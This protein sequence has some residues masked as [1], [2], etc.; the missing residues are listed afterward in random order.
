MGK[1]KVHSGEE[2]IRKL[3]QAEVLLHGGNQQRVTKLVGLLGLSFI[4]M[5][6]F[7]LDCRT[8]HGA[9][10]T[11]S[12]PKEKVLFVHPPLPS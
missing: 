5:L 11:V 2:I 4:Q 9:H 1:R 8:L 7:C 3:R 10:V 6:Q 12:V